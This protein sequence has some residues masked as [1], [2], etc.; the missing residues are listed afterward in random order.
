M[1]RAEK[2][3]EAQRLRADGKVWQEIAA[4]LGVSVST[5]RRWVIP[6]EN[7]HHLKTALAW[8]E[9]NRDANRTRDR[10]YCQANG[11]DQCPRCGERKVKK[12]SHCQTCRSWDHHAFASEFARLWR[13][14]LTIKEL[15]RHFGKSMGMAARLT[16][17][18]RQEGYDLPYRYDEK[19]R[20]AIRR[21]IAEAA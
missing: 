21:G 18:L 3:A 16:F 7:A 12:A 14:G 9:R 1:T 13:N 2:V 19:H 4:S 15:A 5:T 10:A 20:K 6:G 8:K 17:V 11:Y